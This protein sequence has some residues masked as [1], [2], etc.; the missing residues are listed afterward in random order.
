MTNKK[1]NK[2]YK[3]RRI[4]G[5]VLYLV[6]SVS[7]VLLPEQ[8]ELIILGTGSLASYLGIESWRKPKEIPKIIQKKKK[9]K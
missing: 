4:Q 9:K 7:Y 5:A 2:W 8:Y 6:A 1:I 3:S